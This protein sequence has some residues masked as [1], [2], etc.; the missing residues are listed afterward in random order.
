M[1]PLSGGHFVWPTRL[2]VERGL[3]VRLTR[4]PKG[5]FLLGIGVVVIARAPQT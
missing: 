5:T 1:A 2:D 4:F 3:P